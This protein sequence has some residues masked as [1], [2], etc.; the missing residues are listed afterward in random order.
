[1]KKL[2]PYLLGLSFVLAPTSMLYAATNDEDTESTSSSD[3]SDSSDST[4]SKSTS[5]GLWTAS[6]SGSPAGAIC[7]PVRLISSVSVHNYLLNGKIPIAELTIDTLGNNSIRMYTVLSSSADSMDLMGVA[8]AAKGELMK[9]SGGMPSV[10]KQY[11]NTT[12]AHSIEYSLSSVKQLKAVYNSVCKCL[13]TGKGAK[14]TV[15]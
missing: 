2:L 5:D 14:L 11:P 9:E 10:A 1:M 8:T 13:A 4:E 7:I 3:S 12:H 15:K 6:I